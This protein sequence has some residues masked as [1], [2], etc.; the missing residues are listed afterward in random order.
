MEVFLVPRSRG[1]ACKDIASLVLSMEVLGPDSE[2]VVQKSVQ[3]TLVESWDTHTQII[4]ARQF[5]LS[6]SGLSGL[7]SVPFRRSVY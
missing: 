1:G 6:G 7:N 4:N 5:V 3:G 2:A